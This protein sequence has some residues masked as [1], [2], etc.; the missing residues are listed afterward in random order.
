MT[1]TLRVLSSEISALREQVDGIHTSLAAD[2]NMQTLKRKLD[3]KN[4]RC[5]VLQ[6][7]R[8]YLSL[9]MS[10]SSTRIS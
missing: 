4:I 10:G 5:Q 8:P 3:E 9:T 1:P 2:L 6:I 7:K